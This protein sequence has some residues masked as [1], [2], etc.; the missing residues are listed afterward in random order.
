MTH[1]TDAGRVK[2]TSEWRTEAV[3]ILQHYLNERDSEIGFGLP[4]LWFSDGIHS[5]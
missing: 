1:S 5:S 4:S 3:G 2:L